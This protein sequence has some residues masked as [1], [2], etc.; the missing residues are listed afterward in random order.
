VEETWASERDESWQEKES[1][2][3]K[4]GTP[5]TIAHSLPR[6]DLIDSRAV[7][8]SIRTC[9]FFHFSK[10]R[11][12]KIVDFAVSACEHFEISACEVSR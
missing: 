3:A 11:V 6:Q 12:T 1:I 7:C 5:M 9:S 2:R 4:R 10:R 8:L